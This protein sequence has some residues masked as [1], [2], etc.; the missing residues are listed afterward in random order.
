ME[1]N[2]PLMRWNSGDVDKRKVTWKPL[3][4]TLSA[5]PTSDNAPLVFTQTNGINMQIASTGD[6]VGKD[7]RGITNSI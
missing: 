1:L 7:I 6:I 3:C 4:P 2:E 5:N